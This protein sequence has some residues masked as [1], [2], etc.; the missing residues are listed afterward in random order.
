MNGP[1]RGQRVVGGF[2]VPPS[3]HRE[4]LVNIEKVAAP[5]TVIREFVRPTR[6]NTKPRPDID[7]GSSMSTTIT[8]G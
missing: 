6:L 5:Q 4:V 2:L 8:R 3:W 7:R 1:E